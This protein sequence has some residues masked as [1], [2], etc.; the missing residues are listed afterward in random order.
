MD[1]EEFAEAMEQFD[2]EELDEMAAEG[3][4]FVKE[5]AEHDAALSQKVA[6]VVA[7]LR[8]IISHVRS[9]AEN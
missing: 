7:G 5:L 8:D 4:V 3:D 2:P 1:K 6:V 9:R